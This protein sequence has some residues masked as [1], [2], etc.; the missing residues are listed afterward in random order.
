MI[1]VGEVDA[2]F[3]MFSDFFGEIFG[4]GVGGKYFSTGEINVTKFVIMH[5]QRKTE[6]F[7]LNIYLLSGTCGS[8]TSNRE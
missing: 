6:L 2:F 3:G 5:D 7:I 1:V 4:L 8:V